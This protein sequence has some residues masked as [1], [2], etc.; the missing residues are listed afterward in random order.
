VELDKILLGQP[1]RLL[2]D[3]E[4]LGIQRGPQNLKEWNLLEILSAPWQG[5]QS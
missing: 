2:V 1:P 5:V 3:C 4:E